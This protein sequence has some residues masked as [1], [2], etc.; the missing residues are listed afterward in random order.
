MKKIV[1]TITLIVTI[2][3]MGCKKKTQQIIVPNN[4]PNADTSVSN[5]TIERFIT[6][7]YLVLLSR[8][9]N[10]NE[11]ANHLLTLNSNTITK[12]EREKFIDAIQ[13]TTEYKYQLWEFARQNLF[14]THAVT[15]KLSNSDTSIIADKNHSIKALIDTLAKE[16]IADTDPDTRH[17]KIEFYKDMLKFRSIKSE[18]D[19]NNITWEEINKR[20]CNT[21]YYWWRFGQKNKNIFVNNAFNDLLLRSPTDFELDS[22]VK[23]IDVFINN[24]DHINEQGTLFNTKCKTISDVTSAIISTDNFYEAQVRLFYK[25][26][27][28]NEPSTAN[29]LKYTSL[30]IKSKNYQL[31][32]KTILAS[33]EFLLK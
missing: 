33:N 25:R 29:L 2:I 19:N 10:E 31:L 17:I 8:K 22:A 23:I 6:N 1:L 24:S 21:Y 32:Q 18:L 28:Y 12:T 5:V 9:A 13:K 14:E 4:V 15:F 20:F 7:T 11:I 30:Y 16:M 27:F 3:T 26:A